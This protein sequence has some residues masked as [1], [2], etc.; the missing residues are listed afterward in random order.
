MIKLAI[1]DVADRILDSY[2]LI[3]AGSF[4]CMP[5]TEGPSATPT[6]APVVTVAPTPFECMIF[7]TQ[8]STDLVETF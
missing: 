7:D 4:T 2:V 3:E 6:E 1:A 5:K 8:P